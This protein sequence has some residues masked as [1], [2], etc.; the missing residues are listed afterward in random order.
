MYLFSFHYVLWISLKMSFSENDTGDYLL[1]SGT[2]YI[3]AIIIF[4]T[5]YFVIQLIV[6]KYNLLSCGY[7]LYIIIK[8][9][10]IICGCIN[11]NKNY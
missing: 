6:F 2:V 3:L 5:N 10:L 8:I 7:F 11:K 9:K 4:L 1:M